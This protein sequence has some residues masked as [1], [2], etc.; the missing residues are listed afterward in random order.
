MSVSPDWRVSFFCS[1]KR[2][3]PKK[4]LPSAAYSLRCFANLGR[5]AQR[6]LADYTKHSLPRSL[7]GARRLSHLTL[8]A[9]ARQQ[10]IKTPRCEPAIFLYPNLNQRANMAVHCG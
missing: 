9:Q 5:L 10:G 8:D 2:K 4:T 1:A 3:K 6:A 7:N